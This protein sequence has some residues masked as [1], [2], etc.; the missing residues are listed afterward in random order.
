[1]KLKHLWKAAGLVALSAILILT[2]CLA[3]LLALVLRS[4]QIT[5]FWNA[6]LTKLSQSLVLE[7]GRYHFTGEDL[8][9]QQDLWLMLVGR[10]GQVLWQYNKPAEVPDQYDLLDVAA[11]TRWYLEDYPVQTRIRPDGLLV[12]GAPKGSTWKLTISLSEQILHLLP[13]WGVLLFFLSLICVLALAALLL[14]RWFRQDQQARDEAR[15]DW[16]NGI[17]HDIRTPL[18]MVMGYAGQLEADSALPPA[19]RDQAAIIR[20]QSQTI[21]DL[22]NDLNLTMRLDCQM[23]ALRKTKLDLAPFLRQTA[24]DFLNSGLAEGFSLALDLPDQPLPSLEADEFLLRRALNNLLINC[25][26]HNPP[27][28]VIRL[29][30]RQTG[31]A[32]LLWVENT[33]PNAPAPP[34]YQEEDG[35]P[36]H[37]TG[38][39]LVAQIAA[40]HGG[41]ATFFQGETFLC[42]LRVPM[43]PSYWDGSPL[44]LKNSRRFWFVLQNRRGFSCPYLLVVRTKIPANSWAAGAIC[45]SIRSRSSRACTFSRAR[46]PPVAGRPG[47]QK[48]LLSAA[49]RQRPARYCRAPMGLSTD[50]A[51]AAVRPFPSVC[52]LGELARRF[53]SRRSK[54]K[55][56]SSRKWE[57]PSS[58]QP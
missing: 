46:M 21:R 4:A 41:Q 24:A 18:S 22:V 49:M 32:C 23:Q 42:Q 1:M 6:P 43:R 8:L 26:R 11:F 7:E 44:P 38:L 57:E 15:S 40:A 31:K 56:I 58:I 36:A 5:Q 19:R 53:S 51:V 29:G 45:A 39:K 12:A 25:V 2:L 55:A 3:G 35:G 20:R 52:S 14:R 37:G 34:L 50:S 9:A 33:T 47:P 54:S 28:A 48:Q 13:V 16:I 17:S 10:D 27:G 30:A